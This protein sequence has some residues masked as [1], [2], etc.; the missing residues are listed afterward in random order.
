MKSSKRV[1]RTKT[2]KQLASALGLPK[3]VGVEIQVRSDLNDRLIRIVKSD[4][5]T[6]A[7]LARLSGASR[8]RITA[9]LNRSLEGV[10]TD[11]LLRLLGSLGYVVRMN[12]KR[13]DTRAA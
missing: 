9:I 6:H 2:S 8:T 3:S 5:I 7:Q 10:S 1:I 4:G 11:L 13:V 12:V